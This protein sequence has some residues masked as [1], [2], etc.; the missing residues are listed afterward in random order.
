MNTRT[1]LLIGNDK[2][3]ILASS[4]VLVFGLGGVGGSAALSLVRSGVGSVDVVDK[5]TFDITNLNRQLLSDLD[6]IGKNKTDIFKE[7]AL[8]INKD[9]NIKLYNMFFN[10]DTYDKIPLKEYDYI[11]DCIDNIT[12]KIYL[13]E[14]CYN[15]KIKLISSMG[16]GKRLDPSKLVITDLFKTSYDKIAKVMRHELK[17][18]GVY[19]LK[20]VTSTE[21]PRNIK[22]DVI[23][24]I[25]FVP[26]ACG[27]LLSSYVVRDLVDEL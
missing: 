19:K 3:N 13:A 23:P 5:D 22:S 20:V 10:K 14:Y 4:K 1:A 9:V 24:S 8:K 17:K 2:I 18:R 15:N 12:A 21:I 25:Y 26:N 16:T 27:I 6:S 7:K 11:I